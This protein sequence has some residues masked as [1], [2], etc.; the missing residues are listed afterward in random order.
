MR[1]EQTKHLRND[2]QILLYMEHEYKP[3]N[4][5]KVIENYENKVRTKFR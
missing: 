1:V 5:R 2:K 4:L 3:F